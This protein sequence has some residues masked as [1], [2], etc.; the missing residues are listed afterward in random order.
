MQLTEREDHVC[1]W[2][3]T[4]GPWHKQIWPNKIIWFQEGMWFVPSL[5]C[6]IAQEW[7][8]NFPTISSLVSSSS[9]NYGAF[10]PLLIM[11]VNLHICFPHLFL[12][13]WLKVVIM[14]FTKINYF[15]VHFF[16]CICIFYCYLLAGGCYWSCSSEAQIL[17]LTLVEMFKEK[18]H[19]RS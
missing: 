19:D 17:N 18:K 1:E 16:R 7:V 3:S 15:I 14:T 4:I 11:E 8:L 12:I 13:S 2:S 10:L 9:Q 5:R 6:T